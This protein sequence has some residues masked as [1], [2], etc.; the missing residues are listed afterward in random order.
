RDG[1]IIRV[2]H[3]VNQIFARLVRPDVSSCDL[4][5]LQIVQFHRSEMFGD[6][7]SGGP[8]GSAQFRDG[9]FP[10]RGD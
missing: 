3:T 8:Q 5:E 1:Q 2:E 9:T 10:H 7:G 6:V 4:Q